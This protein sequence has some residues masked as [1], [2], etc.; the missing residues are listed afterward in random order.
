MPQTNILTR[1]ISLDV[2]RVLA[3][4]MVIVCHVNNTMW[5]N[6]IR[7]YIYAIGWMGVPIFVI[8][9]GYLMLPRR[10]DRDYIPKFLK[11]NLLPLFLALEIWNIIY[12]IIVLIQS[13]TFNL[14]TAK[15][16]LKISLFLGPTD[17][18]FWFM[19]LIVGLYLGLPL[20]AML[21]QK[22]GMYTHIIIACIVY[23]GLFV[24]TLQQIFTSFGNWGN[25]K[26][27][28]EMNLF[29]SSVWGGSIWMLYLYIGYL[30]HKG[31][32]SNMPLL[33]LIVIFLLSLF[34]NAFLI[35]RQISVENA[36][37]FYGA[38]FFLLSACSFVLIVRGLIKRLKYI[39]SFHTFFQKLSQLS[40]AVYLIHI[41]L[42]PVYRSYVNDVIPSSPKLGYFLVLVF[43]VISSYCIGYILSFIPL[44]KRYGLLIK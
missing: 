12:Y 15:H 41:W 21:V 36:Q 35:H 7:A 27:I 29:G 40:F 6:V 38:L 44:F 43:T 32:F 34:A 3:V 30:F 28:L 8:L 33:L 26:P 14:E 18:S 11:N 22:G 39:S 1:D 4:C 20:F 2:I 19:P 42:I 5:P 16:F 13:K 23:F 25:I 24:C 10:F 37:P 17:S 31:A 9:T